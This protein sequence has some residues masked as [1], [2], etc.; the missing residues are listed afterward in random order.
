MRLNVGPI[1]QNRTSDL[2]VRNEPLG[3]PV[4][5]GADG[6]LEA[7]GDFLFGDVTLRLGAVGVWLISLLI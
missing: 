5:Y 7:L 2:D 1:K 3:L 4:L 6:F